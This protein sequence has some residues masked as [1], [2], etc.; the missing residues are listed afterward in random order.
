MTMER[1]EKISSRPFTLTIIRRKPSGFIYQ[2]DHFEEYSVDS[3]KLLKIIDG[4]VRS[5]SLFEDEI[6]KIGEAQS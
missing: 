3:E 1:E 2:V 4:H 6:R 5:L